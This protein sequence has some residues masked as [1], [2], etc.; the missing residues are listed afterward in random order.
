MNIKTEVESSSWPSLSTPLLSRLRN[1]R[2]PRPVPECPLR[3]IVASLAP[4][5]PLTAGAY[6]AYRSKHTELKEAYK[7]K[8]YPEIAST[9]IHCFLTHPPTHTHAHKSCMTGS[10]LAD[11]LPELSDSTGQVGGVCQ[12]VVGKTFLCVPGVITA[13]P[14]QLL[15]TKTCAYSKYSPIALKYDKCKYILFLFFL[16]FLHKTA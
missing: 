2:G 13:L 9:L 7:H 14:R 15:H 6:F 16:F 5:D 8:Q 4:P 10:Y 11:L 3:A 1:R 12:T